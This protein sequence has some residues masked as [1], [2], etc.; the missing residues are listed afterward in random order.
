M[1]AADF[2]A[3][4]HIGMRSDATPPMPAPGEVIVAVEAC[5]ICGSDLHMYRNDSY[6]DRLTRR[7]PEGYTVPGHEF[8]GRI[9]A[10]GEGVEGW[11]LGQRVVGVTGL[12]G[13]MADRVAVP[14]NPYQLVAMPDGVSFAEAATTEPMADGLQMVRKAAIRD[15][16]NVAVFGVGIIGLGVIQAIR[17]R[18]VP[19]GRIVAIDVQQARLDKA[20]EIGA[21]DIVNPRDGDVFA[22]V[23][24][25]C[26]TEEGYR[27]IS[28]N[29]GV[30]FDCAGYI[31]HMAGPPPLET[32]LR[33][34]ALRDG[35]II[36]FG[37]FEGAMTIDMGPIIQKEP[38]ILGSNG[39]APEELVEAL[40]LMR[41]GAVDRRTLISH[42][43]PLS[44]IGE[45]FETQCRPD[46]V[47]VMLEIGPEA[48]A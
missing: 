6:R 34:I 1:K 35:R 14:A 10:L 28:A 25:V 38:A 41:S 26:G 3:P 32:A 47:K 31:A 20:L 42:R 17:A 21:T 44:A 24:A 5:G 7:T 43:L 4:G 18:G 16:E 33:L 23:A 12:G 9:A 13:G 15:G 39:Y 27:G 30:V 45:A 48:A 2:T 22:Q 36:C 46:A 40:E 8:A 29:I 11:Q 37:G 19:V